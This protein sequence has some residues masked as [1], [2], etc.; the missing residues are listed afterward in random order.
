VK[1]ANNA[2]KPPIFLSKHCTTILVRHIEARAGLRYIVRVPVEPCFVPVANPSLRLVVIFSAATIIAASCQSNLTGMCVRDARFQSS[3]EK[4]VA[5]LEAHKAQIRTASRAI[6]ILQA[7]RDVLT[8][9]G[10]Q[11]SGQPFMP[12]PKMLAAE[13]LISYSNRLYTRR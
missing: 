5:V 10:S 9:S 6:S 2:Q 3:W 11:N 7:M 4:A 13:L 1:Y 12:F 8:T